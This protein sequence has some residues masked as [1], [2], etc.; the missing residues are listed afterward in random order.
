MARRRSIKI[1]KE[2]AITITRRALGTHKLVYVA[3]ANK[4]HKYPFRYRSRILYIGTT[5][6]GAKRI[7]PSAAVRAEQLLHNH[8]VKQLDFHVITCAPLR[9]VKTW[10]KLERA[11]L[12]AFK[13][14]YGSVPIAN[15]MGKHAK[16][17][18][19][20]DYFSEKRL[21]AALSAFDR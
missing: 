8:G 13:H 7:A 9:K 1:A 11:L 3:V 2:P 16:W 12:L 19:E 20:L 10:I 4:R 21:V 18:D 6:A 17:R 14:R 15:T 5:R